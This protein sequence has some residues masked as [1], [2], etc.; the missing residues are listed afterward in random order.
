MLQGRRRR[1]SSLQTNCSTRKSGKRPASGLTISHIFFDPVQANFFSLPTST[2]C[3]SLSSIPR[4]SLIFYQSGIPTARRHPRSPQR[5]EQPRPQR[6]IPGLPAPQRTPRNIRLTHSA[7][8]EFGDSPTG[9]PRLDRVKEPKH[10]LSTLLLTL[11][12]NSLDHHFLT[13]QLLTF[14]YLVQRTGRHTAAL[15]RETVLLASDISTSVRLSSLSPSS[16][17]SILTQH[18]LAVLEYPS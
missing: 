18:S 9:T 11:R 16:H 15:R 7:I 4:S 14:T 2:S 8:R 1:R 17:P 6:P 10:L 12:G 3:L 5:T 13:L